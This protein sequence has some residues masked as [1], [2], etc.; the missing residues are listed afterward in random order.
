MENSCEISEPIFTDTPIV[1]RPLNFHYI[2]TNVSEG[3]NLPTGSL[4]AQPQVWLNVALTDPSGRSVWESGYLDTLGDLADMHSIDVAKGLVPRDANLFNLQTKFLITNLKGTDREVA[5]PVNVDI[6]QIP[7]LRPGAVPIS[8]LNHPPFIRMEAH[9][10]P[11]LDSRKAKYKVPAERLT[12]PGLYRL[13][14]RLRSRVEPS[15]F[16]RFVGST[17]EMIN[18]MNHQILDIHTKSYPFYVQ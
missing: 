8:V 14:V 11:P 2:V 5:L 9:S 1:N 15:Y 3:H 4:G 17:P 6:D 16:M 18:R 7:F 13:D 10:I 12:M